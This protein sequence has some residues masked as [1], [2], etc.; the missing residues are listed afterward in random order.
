DK[1][2]PVIK[3]KQLILR[4][5]LL[6]TSDN[7]ELLASGDGDGLGKGSKGLEVKVIQEVLIDLGF[8]LGPAGADG[9]FGAVTENAIKQFQKNYEPTY[10]TYNSYQ[11]GENDGVVMRNTIL[12]L[13][14]AINGHWEYINDAMDETLEKKIKQ[15]ILE[16]QLNPKG[17]LKKNSL[18][19][20][21]F[22]SDKTVYFNAI[23]DNKY[24]IST[25]Q[26]PNSTSIKVQYL[27][28]VREDMINI[29]DH[30][31]MELTYDGASLL[32]TPLLTGCSIAIKK[33]K[34]KKYISHFQPIIGEN[35]NC[36]KQGHKKLNKRLI[37]AGY[38]VYGPLDYGDKFS[39]FIGIR[40]GSKWSF[41]VQEHKSSLNVKKLRW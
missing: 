25:T 26:S 7:L 22:E 28:V 29:K 8:D 14:E 16:M 27:S 2:T 37:K 38:K 5:E 33:N 20:G 18:K 31:G 19:I 3:V 10:T 34:D 39:T 21:Y 24:Q 15:S 13:D 36:D 11:L 9:D 32:V 35:E 12:G 30:L 17:F 40:S 23:M 41:F 4:S 1:N 6:S